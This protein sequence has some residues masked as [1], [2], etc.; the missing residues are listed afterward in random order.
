MRLAVLIQFH[1]DPLLVRNRARLMRALN[2]TVEIHGVYGGPERLYDTLG[3]P[4]RALLRPWVADIHCIRGRTAFWKRSH[5][6]LAACD[7]YRDG[8]CRVSF[9]ALVV[10]QWDLLMLAPLSQLYA[11]VPEGAVGVTALAPLEAVRDQWPWL[12]YSGWRSQLESLQAHLEREYG[13]RGEVS[14]SLGP[15]SILPRAFLEAYSGLEVPELCHDEVRLPLY[16]RAL[17]FDVVDNGFHGR[18]F[19]PRDERIFNADKHPIEREAVRGELAR[20]DGRRVF[21]PFVQ[22]FALAEAGV[23]PRPRR[24][25]DATERAGSAAWR[26]AALVPRSLRKV[27]RLVTRRENVQWPV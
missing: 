16:A 21:H 7:W 3:G 4:L 25:S 8:G 11:R 2:P 9:D 20:S 10:L 22:P 23:E 17:G 14:A 19:D 13:F 18:W 26:L 1:R 6:D 24:I 27:K 15:G 5:T 12:R